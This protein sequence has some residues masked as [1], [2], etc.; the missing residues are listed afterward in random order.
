MT[1]ITTSYSDLITKEATDYSKSTPAA[2]LFYWGDGSARGLRVE[3]IELMKEFFDNVDFGRGRYSSGIFSSSNR[4]YSQA[5][6][7][8][9][10][11]AYCSITSHLI[12]RTTSTS[13][14]RFTI[15]MKHPKLSKSTFI[16][17]SATTPPSP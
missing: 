2:A 4:V 15:I 7:F 16:T 8:Q 6:Y 17:N 14:T 5:F 3:S 9:I 11:R 10:H 13:R 12:S 1:S